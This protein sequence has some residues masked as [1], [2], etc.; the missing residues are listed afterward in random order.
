LEPF[1]FASALASSLISFLA[2]GDVASLTVVRNLLFVPD[3]LIFET[4]Y[5]P[6]Q[7]YPAL[8][9]VFKVQLPDQQWML[10]HCSLLLLF[11]NPDLILANSEFIDLR[12]SE[13]TTSASLAYYDFVR[14]RSSAALFAASLFCFLNST[15]KGKLAIISSFGHDLFLI[16]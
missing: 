12:S 4:L 7:S 16:S 6:L 1:F 14:A 3:N 11:L 5:C 9:V 8:R 13:P 2:A 10:Q 15:C